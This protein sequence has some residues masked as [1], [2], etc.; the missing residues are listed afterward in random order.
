MMEVTWQ[1]RNSKRIKETSKSSIHILENKMDLLLSRLMKKTGKT[2][3]NHTRVKTINMHTYKLAARVRNDM[4]AKPFPYLTGTHS[5][6][7]GISL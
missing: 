7:L 3:D 4:K 5:R 6:R 1:W 2:W